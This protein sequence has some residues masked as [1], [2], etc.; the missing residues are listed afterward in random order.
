MFK[1]LARAIRQEEMI[2]IEKEQF[3]PLFT[4][5]MILNIRDLKNPTRKLLEIIF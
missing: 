4:D 2:Q 5:D 1:T 3:N